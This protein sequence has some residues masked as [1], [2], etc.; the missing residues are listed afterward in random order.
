MKTPINIHLFVLYNELVHFTHIFG[1]KNNTKNLYNA[2]DTIYLTYGYAIEK[3][4]LMFYF[5]S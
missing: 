1:A 2:H 5:Y 4:I 3:Y